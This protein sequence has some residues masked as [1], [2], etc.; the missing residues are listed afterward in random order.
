MKNFQGLSEISNFVSS[1]L[2]IRKGEFYVVLTD[3]G[4][5]LFN[6]TSDGKDS[7]FSTLVINVSTYAKNLFLG[8][9]RSPM[10]ETANMAYMIAMANRV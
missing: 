6:S 10:A 4:L 5:L 8:V 3:Y 1:E 7:P 9:I 2:G